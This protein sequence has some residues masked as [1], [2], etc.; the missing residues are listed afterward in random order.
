MIRENLTNEE[1]SLFHDSERGWTEA[2]FIN[3]C[4]SC[5]EIVR[6]IAKV[7]P[8]VNGV[9]KI[10]VRV[11]AGAIVDIDRLMKIRVWHGERFLSFILSKTLKDSGLD[12]YIV[13][14]GWKGESCAA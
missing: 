4:Y 10:T 7:L 13:Y 12:H 5:D 9:G 3:P 1:F 14:F 2:A 8:A 11:L 6:Q